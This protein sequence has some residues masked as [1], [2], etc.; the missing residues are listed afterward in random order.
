MANKTTTWVIEFQDKITSGLAKAQNSSNSLAAAFG[1]AAARVVSFGTHTRT[2]ATSVSSLSNRINQ[3]KAQRDILPMSEIGK[4]RKF[5][6]EIADL[7]KQ[8]G[9]MQSMN[10]SWFKS[11]FSEAISSLPGAGFFTNPLVALGAG[12]GISVKKGMENELARINIVT[13]MQGDEQAAD[14]LFGKIS[15]YAKN[16]VYDKG[17]LID[18]QKTM[19]SFGLEADKSFSTLQHIGDIA[20]GDSSRMQALSLAFA[21]ATSTGKL[22]GQDLMQ[23]INAGFNPLQ[24]ISEKTGRSMEDLKAAMSKGEISA[25]MLAQ[26]YQWATEEGGR[27]YQGAEKAGQTL[28]GRMNKMQD[29]LSEMA[30]SLFSAIEPILSPIVDFA[31]TIFD[32]IGSGITWIID[33]FKE[34]NPIVTGL[35]GAIGGLTIAV[36]VYKGVM[37]I[38]TLVQ[39]RFTLA[40][41]ASNLALLGN[42]IVLVVGLVAGLI[43]AVVTCWNKFEGFR[44]AI[45]GVWEVIKGFGN[46]LKDFVIDR[47]KGVISGL[48]TMG[49]AIAKLFK[50]DFEGAWADAKSGLAELSGIDAVKNAIESGKKLGAA[51]EKGVAE[52]RA[53]FQ[54]DKEKRESRSP[55]IGAKSVTGVQTPTVKPLNPKSAGTGG[56]SGAS[57]ISG[58]SGGGK[59]ITMNVTLNNY[60]NGVKNPDE[61][62][63]QVV[64]KINDRLNDSLAAAG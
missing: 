32:S 2:L 29:S 52:G 9:K 46:I 4:I 48:G 56:K 41:I 47:I 31:T 64:R 22:M 20:M 16:T 5:N 35:A 17:S 39:N 34:G 26:A 61:F 8:M 11:K 55:S 25:E 60:I 37:A 36:G 6:S 1:A 45:Y 21:Q 57:G 54:A 51:H 50:G 12:L 15:E 63:E 40:T 33:K 18:A 49:S 44:A 7:E 10:G 24:T 3:L 59:S 13:L 30:I 38:A 19:M 28:S 14:K 43:A 62:A 23:M 58:G 42:S 27:F 53:S